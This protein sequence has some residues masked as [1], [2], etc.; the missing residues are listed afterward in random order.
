MGRRS[1]ITG[2]IMA[3]ARE[4]ARQ[5]RIAA[6]NA[7]R[8][9][10]YAIREEKRIAR[11]RLA[12]ERQYHRTQKEYEKAEKA[13]YLQGRLQEVA[14]LNDDLNETLTALD[15]ILGDTLQKNDSISFSSLRITDGPPQ[16][17]VPKVLAQPDLKPI[18]DDFIRYILKPS[19]LAALWPG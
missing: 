17:S 14:D 9:E 2:I 1:G 15:R 16:L 13:K 5:Q 12:D 10:R 11:E 19:L 6:T 3:M 7:E 18:E 8:A 4:S